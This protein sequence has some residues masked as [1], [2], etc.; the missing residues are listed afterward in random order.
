MNLMMY[1]SPNASA[2]LFHAAP[3][4]IIDPIFYAEV[5]GERAAVV[6]VLDADRVRAK[7]GLK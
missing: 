2:D 4:G 6:S 5:E 1:G 3:E 7:G